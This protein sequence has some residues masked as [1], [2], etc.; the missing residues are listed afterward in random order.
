LGHAAATVEEFNDDR[1]V[2]QNTFWLP[3]FNLKIMPVSWMDIRL[4]YTHSIARPQY[5]SY[6]PRY[7]VNRDGAMSNIGNPDLLPALSRNFD[8]YVSFLANRLGLL[9]LGGFYKIIEGYEFTK[10]FPNLNDASNEVHG[11]DVVAT[12][13][14][15]RFNIPINNPHDAYTWGMEA[16]W[17]TVFWYL[18]G[19][20][21]GLVFNINYTVIE[22]EQTHTTVVLDR[23]V[24]DPN[25]PRRF[26]IVPRDSTY[27]R[28][29]YNQPRQ[30][31]NV[32]L[33]YD[34]G[35]FSARLAHSR[36]SSVFIDEMGGR[37]DIVENFRYGSA[38]NQWDLSVTQYVPGVSGLQLFLNMT[39][40][41]NSSYEET[42]GDSS[43]GGRFPLR[44]EYY[45]RLT[46]IGLRYR[47]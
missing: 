8:V 47:L 28:P 6:M 21:N 45:G 10:A 1:A 11:Y 9:T 5:Y 17:Q 34:I 40:I 7:R 38:H 32:S 16:D 15:V 24:P 4:A 20:L 3:M 39:N 36:R 14:Q 12:N 19:P 41:S 43:T 13:R 30:I 37:R 26:E 42:I 31:L 35:G 33:G 22:T 27:L 2:K 44:H 23:I 25:F 18:P 46:I 29:L